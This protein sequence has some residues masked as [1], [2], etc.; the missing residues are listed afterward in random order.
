[1]PG[2]LFV[3]ATPIGNLEDFTFRAR[4]IL[5]EVDLIA[6]EDTRRTAKLL[7]HYE[8]RKPLVSLREHNEFREAPRLLDR[9]A[10][11]ESIALV[12][13]AGT[14]TVAD[15]GS[16]LVQGART[17]G[18]P[19]VPVPGPSAVATALSAS[20]FDA[21]SF[22]FLG[23]PPAKGQA[24]KNWF[25]ALSQDP[26]VQVLFEAPHRIKRT[27]AELEKYLVKRH[28]LVFR[29]LTKINEESGLYPNIDN[30]DWPK[31][32]GEFTIAIGPRT[33]MQ[34]TSTTVAS[35]QQPIFDLYQALTSNSQI[36]Q[37]VA[38]E[39][40]ALK[41]GLQP[42]VVRKSVKKTLILVKNQNSS[43]P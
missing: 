26:R 2:T 33:D 10:A 4:R 25:E 40:I 36:P 6:A 24:R 29:E 8:I 3:V 42:A 5:G 20:G 21:S 37:E 18:I 15:P 34:D 31:S 30:C 35:N 27:L 19:V 12:S 28:I 22:V 17:R 1:M 41:F 9:L 23:F 13:D 16:R 11:G 32:I 43:A 39:L 14:P 38:L 7:A